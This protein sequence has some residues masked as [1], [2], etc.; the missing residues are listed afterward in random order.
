MAKK[1]P[2]SWSVGKIG[3]YE[4]CPKKYEGKYV[5]R[6]PEPKSPAAARGD[7]IHKKAE[8]YIEGEGTRQVPKELIKL[9]TL[10]RRLRRDGAMTEQRISV[11]SRWR[12]TTWTKGWCR[13][14]LDA[15]GISLPRAEIVDHKTGRIYPKHKDQA[16]VYA[17]IVADVD[18]GIE[19]FDVKFAYTDKGVVRPWAFTRGEVMDLREVWAERAERTLSARRFPATPSESACRWCPRRSDKGGDCREWRKV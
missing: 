16:E 8:K 18:E 17:C 12:L 15:L 14:I 10:Y 19:Y 11:D 4:D 6:M 2:T 1:Y 9:A 3:A 13:G 7:A 5:L